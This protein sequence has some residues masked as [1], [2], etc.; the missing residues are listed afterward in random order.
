LK[1]R[2]N[3]RVREELWSVHY[4]KKSGE[5]QNTTLPIYA[6]SRERA[7][8]M[9]ASFGVRTGYEIVRVEQVD[10]Y[11]LRFGAVLPKVIYV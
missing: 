7:V 1:R 4:K 6:P 8:E 3:M 11:V 9:A 5:A 2:K 10:F